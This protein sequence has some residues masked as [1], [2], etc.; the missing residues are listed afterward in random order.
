[1]MDYVPK[2]HYARSPEILAYCQAITRRYNLYELAVFQT[3]VASTVWH[4]EE[5]RWDLTTGLGDHMKARFAIGAN[6]TLSKPKLSKIKGMES[7]KGHPFPY[8]TPG[9]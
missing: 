4:G 9:L 3:A 2:N 7:F 1:M 5:E 6:G 8:L